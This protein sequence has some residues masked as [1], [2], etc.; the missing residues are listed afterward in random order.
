MVEIITA[1][2]LR[3]EL[4]DVVL[5][6]LFLKRLHPFGWYMQYLIACYFL[7]WLGVKYISNQRIRN[8]IWVTLAIVS[9]FLFGN[10]QGEQAISFLSGVLLAEYRNESNSLDRVQMPA[11]GGENQRKYFLTGGLMLCVAVLLLAVKQLPVVRAQNHYWLTLLNLAMK[12]SCAAGCLLVTNGVRPLEKLVL[13]FGRTSYSLYLVH[14]YFMFIIG[15]NVFGNYVVNSIVMLA[16]SL[17][18]AVILNKLN[19]IFT[20]K[21][22]EVDRW[23][24][25]C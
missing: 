5:E 16:L 9:F 1:V 2:I 22:Q 7:F 6:L 17:G 19:G 25:K 10:L 4:S 11:G 3:R 12:T 13:W 24:Q 21:L 23:N 8:G 14:G 20:K 15:N 18:S